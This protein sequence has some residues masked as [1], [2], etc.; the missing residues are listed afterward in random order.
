MELSALLDEI[1]SGIIDLQNKVD[2]LR[3]MDS[4]ELYQLDVLMS[5]KEAANYIGRSI[6][7]LDR[8]CEERKIRREIVDGVVR[9]RRSTLV[10]FKG[11]GFEK[12]KQNEV[13]EISQIINKY[14]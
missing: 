13:S 5:R 10:R 6:R 3:T 12:Q 1:Q 14:L 11:V 4:G 8:L 2:I 9:I 7:Q